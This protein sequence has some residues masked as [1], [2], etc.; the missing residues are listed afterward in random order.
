MGCSARLKTSFE[1]NLGTEGK[2]RTF[3]FL[4]YI[5]TYLMPIYQLM[6]TYI[7]GLYNSIIVSIPADQN[8]PKWM[9]TDNIWNHLS[10]D[11]QSVLLR[12]RHA[13]VV[14][15]LYPASFKRLDRYGVGD[16]TA[17]YNDEFL[18]L[19][20]SER[21]IQHRLPRTRNRSN[22]LRQIQKQQQQQ[23]DEAF[24]L[25]LT[26]SK[27]QLYILLIWSVLTFVHMYINIKWV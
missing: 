2:Q 10:F 21:R 23:H 11:H 1:L 9:Y 14:P 25:V 3:P 20:V 8:S 17:P 4:C 15:N 5:E 7:C 22:H 19:L 27:P 18:Y 13:L 24:C 6:I 26:K 16:Y 12:F